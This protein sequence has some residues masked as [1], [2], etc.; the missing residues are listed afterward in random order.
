MH[1]GSSV[2]RRSYRAANRAADSTTAS[3]VRRSKRIS[4][5]R[6]PGRGFSFL[7]S[8]L[9]WRSWLKDV[10]FCL[11]ESFGFRSSRC[12]GAGRR[13]L[14]RRCPRS[15]EFRDHRF[16]CMFCARFRKQAA[17]LVRRYSKNVD[18]MFGCIVHGIR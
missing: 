8:R 10:V 2:G 13:R 1:V 5:E 4:L 18:G 15:F 6:G 3:L 9:C 7:P 16:L 11:K 17:L 14:V 12:C